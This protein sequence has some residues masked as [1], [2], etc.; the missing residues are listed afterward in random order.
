M[1]L[2][3]YR[4]FVQPVRHLSVESLTVVTMQPTL[5]AGTPVYA[6]VELQQKLRCAFLFFTARNE[7]DDNDDNYTLGRNSWSGGQVSGLWSISL[8]LR[9]APRSQSTPTDQHL[10]PPRV[11]TCQV[12]GSEPHPSHLTIAS[13]RSIASGPRRTATYSPG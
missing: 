9:A 6:H 10:Q 11:S 7:L 8:V 1:S 13:G 5:H 3:R 2:N 12:R 4:Y